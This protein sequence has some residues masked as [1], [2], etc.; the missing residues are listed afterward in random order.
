[1]EAPWLSDIQTSC[2]MIGRGMLTCVDPATLSLNMLDLHAEP[3]M[4]QIPIQVETHPTNNKPAF[5]LVCW[6]FVGPA[7]G[8]FSV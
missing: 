1:M 7:P 4:T 6:F 5:L 3:Q 8:R 2:A